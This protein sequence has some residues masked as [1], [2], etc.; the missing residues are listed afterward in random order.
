M[1][2]LVVDF[3]AL[4]DRQATLLVEARWMADELAGL[5]RSGN[6]EEQA[7]ILEAQI[8]VHALNRTVR[9]F[10]DGQIAALKT[11]ALRQREAD[12]AGEPSPEFTVRR[13]LNGLNAAVAPIH[14][15]IH[16]LRDEGSSTTLSMLLM[17]G[18]TPSLHAIGGIQEELEHVRRQWIGEEESRGD[19]GVCDPATD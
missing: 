16:S 5:V 11:I 18:M 8:L 13:I 4:R 17:S 7:T 14:G 6:A 19:F 10:L 12:A 15:L 3:L 1:E 2:P 9:E